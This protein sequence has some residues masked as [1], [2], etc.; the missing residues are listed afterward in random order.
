[1]SYSP[2]SKLFFE[3][4]LN[5]FILGNLTNTT[6]S[7]RTPIKDNTCRESKETQ[8]NLSGTI[9]SERTPTEDK[10]LRESKET[11]GPN[12]STRTSSATVN[13]SSF[14]SFCQKSFL[15]WSALVRHNLVCHSSEKPYKCA[16]C[17]K[18]FST[19]LYLDCHAKRYCTKSS[20]TQETA[21]QG[22]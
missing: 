8:G 16:A 2:L 6:G 3:I 11:Q 20:A 7:E 15:R 17:D 10:T 18:T 22:K 9:R 1:M 12:V 19:K 13:D 4:V 21:V 5:L 14:C